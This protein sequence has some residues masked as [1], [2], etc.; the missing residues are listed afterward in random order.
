[1]HGEVHKGANTTTRQRQFYWPGQ[2]T[3]TG[4][5]GLL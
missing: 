4:G 2:Y 5:E 3:V 1:M